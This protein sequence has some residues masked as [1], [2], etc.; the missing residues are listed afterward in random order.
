MVD[1]VQSKGSKV[2]IER[3]GREPLIFTDEEVATAQQELDQD[4]ERKRRGLIKAQIENAKRESNPNIPDISLKNRNEQIIFYLNKNKGDLIQAVRTG[5]TSELWDAAQ[6]FVLIKEIVLIL[7]NE[8]KINIASTIKFVEK[9]YLLDRDHQ[10]ELFLQ[11]FTDQELFEYGINLSM[12]RKSQVEM[13]MN[14]YKRKTK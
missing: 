14:K 7:A 9:Y 6:W 11:L 3:K 4:K 2:I 1:D 5:A 13:L 12:R 8:Q 10:D